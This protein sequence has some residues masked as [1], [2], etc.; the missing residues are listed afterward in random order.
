[1]GLKLVMCKGKAIPA[2]CPDTV[3]LKDRIFPE[4]V[5]EKSTEG[6]DHDRKQER[7]RS[8]ICSTTG[9]MV[10]RHPFLEPLRK[11]AQNIGVGFSS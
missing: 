8:V 1:M 5:Q 7:H 6:K 4:A 3:F 10:K 11:L 2:S 9:K